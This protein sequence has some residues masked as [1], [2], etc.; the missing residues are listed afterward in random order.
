MNILGKSIKEFR[1]SKKMTQKQL[2]E[3]TG[4]KQNTIS[5][6]ENGKRQLDE[7]DILTYSKA[8]GV[9]PQQFFDKSNRT[10]DSNLTRLTDNYQKLNKEDKQKLV[11]YSDELA[12]KPSLSL[13]A[14]KGKELNDKTKELLKE[15]Y[16]EQYGKDYL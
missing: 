5:N 16:E 9:D 6:H 4:F 10:S 15:A 2:A 8:L 12:N 11:D 13:A 7:T 14:F 1:K 3:L